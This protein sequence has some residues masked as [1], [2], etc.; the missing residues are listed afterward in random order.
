MGIDGIVTFTLGCSA[1][2]DV[3]VAKWFSLT[4]PVPSLTTMKREGQ[5]LILAP[6]IE[7]VNLAT[8]VVGQ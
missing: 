5:D 7:L 2:A 4:G 6:W 8:L 3:R 1:F